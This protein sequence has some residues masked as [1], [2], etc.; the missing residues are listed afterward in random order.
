MRTRKTIS[1]EDIRLN[2]PLLTRR[3]AM[4]G[5]AAFA[6]QPASTYALADPHF[7]PVGAMT[8]SQ[9]SV[10]RLMVQLGHSRTCSTAVF[11]P[12]SR[13]ILSGSVD[14]TISIWD[15]ATGREVRSFTGHTK[16]VHTAVFS[17]DGRMVLTTSWD[18]TAR[19]WDVATGREIRRFS[20]DD[21]TVGCAIFTPD[22][23][24]I[25]AMGT[26][27]LRLFDTVNGKDVAGFQREHHADS[28]VTPFESKFLVFSRN[29]KSFLEIRGRNARL[30][31]GTTG[32]QKSR[33]EVVTFW[34][35]TIALSPNGRTV[36]VCGDNTACLYDALAGKEIRSLKPAHNVV[37]SGV[38]TPDGEYVLVASHSK[39]S[40][41][42]CASLFRVATG[43]EVRRLL[44]DMGASKVVFSP[45]GKQVLAAGSL[46][47]L[48][49]FVSGRRV[50]SFVG[51]SSEA[52]SAT[53]S[54]DS[55]M[56]VTTN[57]GEVGARLFDLTT[58]KEGHILGAPTFVPYIPFSHRTRSL[59]WQQVTTAQPACSMLQRAKLPRHSRAT[60]T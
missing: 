53:I 9:A 31:D 47:Q 23:R 57:L 35:T 7:L 52:L 36:L 54:P 5:I 1:Y 19:L 39:D 10:P 16:G 13:F 6:L 30:C 33:F 12:N 51:R 59:F 55:R 43:I 45:N 49:D 37:T 17:P 42:N 2:A 32:A 8:A 34:D 14:S 60:L 56:I 27:S 29:G 20:E 58:G 18:G 38:F 48:F 26:S 22:G 11:S 41:A 25:L 15:V 46:V 44:H 40:S 21:Y 50:R 28:T 24:R 4:Q 3:Q